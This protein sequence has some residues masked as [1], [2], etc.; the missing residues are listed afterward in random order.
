MDGSPSWDESGCFPGVPIEVGHLVEVEGLDCRSPL[1]IRRI[2]S[3][4]AD[5]RLMIARL[6]Q[7]VLARRMSTVASCEFAS[8]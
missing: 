3:W 1:L 4:E 8:K 6:R 2:K 5:R 7:A